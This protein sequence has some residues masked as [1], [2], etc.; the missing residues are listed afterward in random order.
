MKPRNLWPHGIITAFVV[1][2]TGTIGLIV[3]ACSNRV[4][5]V[6]ANYYE[7]EIRFQDHM[8]TVRRTQTIAG[9]ASVAFD[10]ASQK[11]A[12]SVPR[13]GA[14]GIPAGA[15]HFYRPSAASLDW[16]IRLQTEHA[17]QSI[18]TS[19]LKP[20]LWIVRVSWR[21]DNQDFFIEK[22][23]NI[24]REPGAHRSTIAQ[25]APNPK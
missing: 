1:F 11:I 23:I 17:T 10:P 9:T 19:E 4:D 7:Q 6:N 15:I 16:E 20:G 8:D 18:D 5:L 21:T 2:I 13:Q 12:I 25:P 24:E 3:L 22:K 14:G